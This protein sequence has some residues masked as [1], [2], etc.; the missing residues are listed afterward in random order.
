MDR[1]QAL[2]WSYSSFGAL[3]VLYPQINANIATV[4]A[5]RLHELEERFCEIATQEVPDR[6]ATSLLRLADSVGTQTP[7]GVEVDLGRR[8]LAELTGTTLHTVSRILSKWANAGWIVARRGG[9]VI[10]DC[11]RLRAF[12]DRGG[13]GP[14][15]CRWPRDRSAPRDSYSPSALEA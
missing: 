12:R 15:L 14:N 1:C 11:E 7:Q 2:V 3:A 9:V 10:P 13:K 8:E 6:L 4:L 5:A